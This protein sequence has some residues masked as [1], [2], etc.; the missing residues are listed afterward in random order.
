MKV[1]V[2]LGKPG[3]GKTM[4]VHKEHPGAYWLKPSH[5]GKLWFDNYL[6]ESTIVMDDFEGTCNIDDLLHLLDSYAGNMQWER[7]GGY[8]KLRHNMVVITCNIDPKEWYLDHPREKRN[9][10]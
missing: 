3:C 4:K 10:L 9:A 2:Y 8:T 6:N 7:K 1:I 5:N